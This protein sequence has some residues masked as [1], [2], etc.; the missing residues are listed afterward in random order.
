MKKQKRKL[1]EQS[2]ASRFIG[3]F[4]KSY[5]DGLEKSFHD[6]AKKRDPELARQIAKIDNDLDEL[7]RYLKSLNK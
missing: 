2:F 5:K 1:N 6:K 3:A 4:F 7:R